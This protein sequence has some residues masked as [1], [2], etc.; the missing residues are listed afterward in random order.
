MGFFKSIFSKEQP[1]LRQV[2]HVSEL[3]QGDAV[4]FSDSFALPE[5]LRKQSFTVTEVNTYQYERSVSN[6]FVLK[7]FHP[8]PIY[9]S[10]EKDDDEWLNLSIKINRDTVAQLFDLDNFSEIFDEE[11]IT[12]LALQQELTEFTNWLA[13]IYFQHCYAERGYFYPKDFRPG[14]PPSHQDDQSQECDSF[15]LTSSDEKFSVD[16]E[17][18]ADGD[19]DV[20]LTIHR[21]LSDIIGLYPGDKND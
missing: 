4:E 5:Q 14:R 20:S 12:E 13:P 8:E 15:G 10:Y 17:V 2:N 19:T 1:Q 11:S 6:E 7:G 9:M 21:P 18:W 3:K 16:V